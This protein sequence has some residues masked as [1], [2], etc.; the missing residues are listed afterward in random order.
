MK[1][2]K[3]VRRR[4]GFTLMEILI[5]IALLGGIIAIVV[6]NLG[7]T[8]GG[9]TADIER[10][11]VQANGSFDL[12]LQ[13]YRMNVGT[14][15]TTDEG[16]QGLLAAPSGKEDRWKGPYVKDEKA[17]KD[18]YGQP[19]RYTFPG[20]HNTNGYDLWSTG[21]DQQDGTPDDIGNWTPG[22]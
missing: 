7:D 18:S 22:K 15:P 17:I 3:P 8:F 4:R 11:K 10:T 5:V 20:T 14:F 1:I 6:V 19:Y 12:A 13:R 9:A 2:R 21:P 16:L